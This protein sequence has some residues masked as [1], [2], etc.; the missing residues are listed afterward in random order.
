[1]TQTI[2]YWIYKPL[3]SYNIHLICNDKDGWKKEETSVVLHSTDKGTQAYG[4]SLKL[5]LMLITYPLSLLLQS[6]AKLTWLLAISGYNIELPL[7]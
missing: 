3:T 6:K 5:S 4:S 2:L 1:M 7:T